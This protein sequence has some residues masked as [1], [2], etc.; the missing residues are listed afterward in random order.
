MKLAVSCFHLFWRLNFGFGVRTRVLQAHIMQ[1]PLPELFSTICTLPTHPGFGW[2]TKT[3]TMPNARYKAQM[4]NDSRSILFI[5][6]VFK[7]HVND[8]SHRNYHASTLRRDLA[9]WN[10]GILK[11]WHK[12]KQNVLL[13]RNENYCLLD[14]HKWSF[15]LQ[16]HNYFIATHHPT[17]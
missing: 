9:D 8:T 16:W 5:I 12:W 2:Q 7:C 11:G 3:L 6:F 17:R 4:K 14:W 1:Q 10:S 15:P 13:D